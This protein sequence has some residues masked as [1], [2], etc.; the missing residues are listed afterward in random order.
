M[1][2]FFFQVLRWLREPMVKGLQGE[3]AL[4][5]KKPAIF[6][7]SLESDPIDKGNKLRKL[8]TRLETKL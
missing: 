1:R 5:R 3:N 8:K 6:R 4:P 7:G 2:K